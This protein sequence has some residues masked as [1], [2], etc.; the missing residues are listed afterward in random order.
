LVR[1]RGLVGCV[2]R[3][4]THQ[5]CRPRCV[6]LRSTHPTTADQHRRVPL[7]G[8]PSSGRYRSPF[9]ISRQRHSAGQRFAPFQVLK[10]LRSNT[11]TAVEVTMPLR[12][13]LFQAVGVTIK[14]VVFNAVFIH[15]LLRH[16]PSNLLL[17]AFGSVSTIS[18]VGLWVTCRSSPDPTY[19][20]QDEV[21]TRACAAI[22]VA[23]QLMVSVAFIGY[24][25]VRS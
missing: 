17:W 22:V 25:L 7:L 21:P 4:G 10:L 3:S 19:Q 11:P 6:P 14:I 1:H 8:S 16:V 12:D 15:M 5:L 24:V 13:Q 20:T 9:H 23:T 18:L 2:E